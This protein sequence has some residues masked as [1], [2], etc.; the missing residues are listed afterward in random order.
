V[1]S[2]AV[3]PD[4]KRAISASY[5]QT[6]KLWNLDSG[7]CLRTFEGHTQSV[8]AVATSPDGRHAISASNDTT[9]KLWDLDSGQCLATWQAAFPFHCCAL[10][11]GTIA[12]GTSGEILFL[13]LMP[14]GRLV[15]ETSATTWH[16]SHML[17]AIARAN[18]AVL[19]K[20][21]HSEPHHFEE[22]A[23]TTPS[24]SPIA[25]LQWSQDGVHLLA[26]ACDGTVYVLD[27]ATL[28]PASPP[29]CPWFDP[30]DV[31]PDGTWRA[32]IRDGRLEVA[33]LRKR[34]EG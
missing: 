34:E 11:R 1:E 29:T 30:S 25:R 8:G 31:S 17:L 22:L 23:R 26:T 13:K 24:G 16:P 19:V 2:V 27:G 32:R 3:L 6:L 9:L 20:Q 4:G 12:A 7:Q 14:P 10:S 33:R 28:H 18:G 21:W 5:D 15:P